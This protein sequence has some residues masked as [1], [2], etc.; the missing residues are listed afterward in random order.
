MTDLRSFCCP[1]CGSQISTSVSSRGYRV[2]TF[3]LLVSGDDDHPVNPETTLLRAKITP[4][5]RQ[6]WLAATE[7]TGD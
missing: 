6:R 2:T 3:T 7:S 5:E 1:S 4:E